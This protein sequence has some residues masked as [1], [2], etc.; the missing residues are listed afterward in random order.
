MTRAGARCLALGLIF[1]VCAVRWAGGAWAISLAEL[2][3]GMRKSDESVGSV[4]FSFIQETR[5]TLTSEVQVS[6]GTAYIRRPKQ[7]RIEQVY[8]ERQIV[9][10]DGKKLSIY[11]P[12]FKQV[13]ED[14]WKRW[15]SQN[16]FFPGLAGFSGAF[17]KLRVNYAWKIDGEC[18]AKDGGGIRVRLSGRGAESERGLE[19]CVDAGDFVPRRTE[20]REGTLRVITTLTA[21]KQNPELPVSLFRLERM[22]GVKIIR[23]H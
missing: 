5:S 17:E 12:R 3:D 7:F 16:S 20:L 11:T 15:M 6:S 18:G 10:S 1:S 14:S 2:Q 13:I 23:M 8:P 4:Q 9:V 21:L 19:L 22:D